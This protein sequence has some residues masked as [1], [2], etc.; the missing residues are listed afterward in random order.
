MPVNELW[1][2]GSADDDVLNPDGP[3]GDRPLDLYLYEYS[4]RLTGAAY[5]EQNQSNSFDLFLLAT[6]N[7]YY[8]C[9]GLQPRL[10]SVMQLL[11]CC[12]VSRPYHRHRGYYYLDHP[13]RTEYGEKEGI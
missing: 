13:W 2:A 8:A 10:S 4:T 6:E 3:E 11:S 12:T 1:I 9:Q 7:V 5:E